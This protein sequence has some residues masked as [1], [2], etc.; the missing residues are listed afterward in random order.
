MKCCHKLAIGGAA[1]TLAAALHA[2]YGTWFGVVAWGSG[3]GVLF[4]CASIV[5]NPQSN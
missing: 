2:A 5:K 4:W 1:M 3:A